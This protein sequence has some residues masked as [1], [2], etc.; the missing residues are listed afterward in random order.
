MVLGDELAFGNAG[1]QN[2]SPGG[3]LA[4]EPPGEKEQIMSEK[5]QPSNDAHATAIAIAWDLLQSIS[6]EGLVQRASVGI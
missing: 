5:I 4:T 6:F 1:G 3:G 2:N